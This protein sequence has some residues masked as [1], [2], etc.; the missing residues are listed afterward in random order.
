MHKRY[1]EKV[2]IVKQNQKNKER[3]KKL[4]AEGKCV[5]CGGDKTTT[6]I[7]CEYCRTRFNALL[8]ERRQYAKRKRK[9]KEKQEPN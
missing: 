5:Q 1:G 6:K 7:L 3:Y 4:K 9:I 8:R 2:R